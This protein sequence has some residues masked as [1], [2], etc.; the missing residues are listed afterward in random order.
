[1]GQRLTEHPCPLYPA[2]ADAGFFLGTPAS[3]GNT[4][5]RQ[6]HDG[7]EPFER[8]RRNAPGRRIPWY[9]RG[10]WTRTGVEDLRAL[11]SSMIQS[12]KWGTSISTV[13]RVN[14]ETLRRRRRQA[15]EKKAAM[16]PLKM[17]IPLVT[18]ILPALFI[19]VVGP[20]VLKIVQTLGR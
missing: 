6:V 1:M 11:V 3:G 5:A 15:A 9:L 14:A 13:L 12:E 8:R 16:A 18:F 10:L 19:I 2:V 7:V 20:T 4:F 17:T